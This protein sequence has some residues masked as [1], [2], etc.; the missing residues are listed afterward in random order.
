MKRIL[1]VLIFFLQSCSLNDPKP[2]IEPVIGKFILEKSVILANTSFSKNKTIN[3]GSEGSDLGLKGLELKQNSEGDRTAQIEV[4]ASKITS[5]TF[6]K[7]INPVTPLITIHAT[8]EKFEE[9]G[10]YLLQIPL[11]KT[12]SSDE[13]AMGFYYEESTGKLEGIPMVQYSSSSITIATRHFSSLFVSVIKKSDLPDN[14]ASGFNPEV[15]GWPFVNYGTAYNRGGICGGMSITAMYAYLYQGGNLVKNA[16]NEGN[17]A[18]KTPTI[19][20]DDSYGI[21][22]SDFGQDEYAR[23]FKSWKSDLWLSGIQ[24]E[25]TYRAFAYS[26]MVTGEPQLV[27]IDAKNSAHAMVVY[28]IRE[29]QLIVYDPNYP[30]NTERLINFKGSSSMTFEP[31]NSAENAAELVA[32]RGKA[33]PHITYAAKTAVA[34]WDRIAKVWTIYKNKSLYEQYYGIKDLKLEIY[35]LKDSL[36]ASTSENT[37]VILSKIKIYYSQPNF[38]DNISGFLIDKEGKSISSTYTLKRGD[39]YIGLYL[40]SPENDGSW[41]GFKWFNVKLTDFDENLIGKWEFYQ[42][43]TKETFYWQFNS[44]GTCIQFIAGKKYDWKWTNENGQL[45]LYVDNG[46]PAY[47]TYKIIGNELYFWVDSMNIWG[48]PFVKI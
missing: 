41:F 38:P 46:K 1:I 16:D 8:N 18:F 24:D 37:S 20:Q 22:Y 29:K 47:M 9:D 23:I 43:E 34:D 40:K 25:L 48:L 32:G 4:S 3:I 39:N 17:T 2:I 6:G 19:W 33:Y 11:S 15:D 7:S 13:F 36:I 26:M 5:H 12:I 45:K 21:I 30:K 35:N 42:A 44:D 27:R 14:I 28:A 10:L 31:Y